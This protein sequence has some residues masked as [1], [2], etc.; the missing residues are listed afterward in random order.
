MGVLGKFIYRKLCEIKEAKWDFTKFILRC[1][2]PHGDYGMCI[3]TLK[4]S[5]LVKWLQTL[6]RRIKQ[7]ILHI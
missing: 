1:Y 3:E 6:Q 4:N 5:R 2:L 7:Y